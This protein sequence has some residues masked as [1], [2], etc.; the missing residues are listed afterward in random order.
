MIPEALIVTNDFELCHM[1][2]LAVESFGI[3][4]AIALSPAD[5]LKQIAQRKFDLVIVDC[6][7]LEH[8]CSALRKMRLNPTH[9][10]AV[11][12]AIVINREHTRYVCDSGANFVVSHANYELEISATLRSAY[13]LVL[14]ERGRYNRFPMNCP[15]KV[16]CGDFR[17]EALLLN[18]SQGG[19]CLTGVGRLSGPI[20][21][22][23]MLE[24]EKPPLQVKGNVVWQ[25]EQRTGVQFTQMSKSARSELDDW[26]AREFEARA[27]IQRPALAGNGRENLSASDSSRTAVYG[28]AE[29]IHPIVT[30]IIR[31]GPVRARCSACQATISFGN[32][33]SQPL[34]QERKLREAFLSHVQEKHPSEVAALLAHHSGAFSAPSNPK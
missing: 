16:R 19:L 4:A 7:D 34:E 26:L 32:T 1:V 8:G 22:S 3:S 18:I 6:S 20:Q 31:G 13:G 10:S 15:V 27:K 14:R 23:F 5:A 28:N 17:G 24:A 21:L 25:R 30:A 33:I 2:R 29:G 9:R 12:V 11:S